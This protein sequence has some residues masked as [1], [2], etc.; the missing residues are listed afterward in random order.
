MFGN[1]DSSPPMS[2]RIP[3]KSQHKAMEW[4][5]VLAS[6]NIPHLLA[7]PDPSGNWSLHIAPEDVS[8]ASAAIRQYELENR[9]RPWQQQY[10]E[11]RIVYDWV[12]LVWALLLVVVH[13]LKERHPVISDWGMMHGVDVWRGQWWRLVT[14]TQLHADW[15]HLASNL[16]VGVVLLGLVMGRWGTATGMLAALLAGVGGNLA[17]LFLRP[18]AYSLG[19]STVVMGCIGLLAVL[20]RWQ[21]PAARRFWRNVLSGISGAVLLF[22]LLGLDPRSDILAHTG[23]FLAGLLLAAV[24]RLFPAL[25]RGRWSDLVALLLFAALLLLPWLSVL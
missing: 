9:T 3:A 18:E 16:S 13:V 17:N 24:L 21:A 8:R 4:S 15:G 11:G 2:A 5:L 25:S 1:A 20:P 14:A 10:L 19:F 6:Q 12:A 7:P 22:M 23:G